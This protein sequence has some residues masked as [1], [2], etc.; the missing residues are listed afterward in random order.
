[1]NIIV[2]MPTTPEG[3]EILSRRLN[4]AHL[5]MVANNINKLNCPYEQKVDLFEKVCSKI[6]HRRY[7]Q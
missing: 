7:E 6:E 5:T 4:E 3:M 1:M 2:H